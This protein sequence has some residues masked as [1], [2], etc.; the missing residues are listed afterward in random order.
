MDT[1]DIYGSLDNEN[2]SKID[3][4]KRSDLRKIYFSFFND[5][6]DYLTSFIKESL[7]E[8]VIGEIPVSVESVR[9]FEDN[10]AGRYITVKNQGDTSCFINTQGQGGFRLD[11][12]EKEK[13]WVNKTVFA[14][15]VSGSTTLGIIKS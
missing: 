13:F 4:K 3:I 8:L 1:I 7:S 5:F 9:I 11:A 14:V 15:T 12:G 6:R 2:D 10:G